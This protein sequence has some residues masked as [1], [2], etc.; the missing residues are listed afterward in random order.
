MGLR[1]FEQWMDALRRTDAVQVRTALAALAAL[2]L[3]AAI[4]PHGPSSESDLATSDREPESSPPVAV[5]REGPR[6][7]GHERP[8]GQ[9]GPPEA[10]LPAED[11]AAALA[12]RA[13]DQGRAS[14]DGV[15][16]DDDGRD[17]DGRDGDDARGADAAEREETGHEETE[18]EPQVIYGYDVEVR[19]EVATDT[20]EFEATLE[21]ILSDARGWTLG[22]SLAFERNADAPDLTVVL[23]SPDEVEATHEVCSRDY[24][25]RVEDEI[26]I[27]DR[28]WRD[29]TPAWHESDGDLTTYR[30]Y[31]INHEVG[32]FLGFG[33]VE[34]GG[35]GERA[36]VMQQQSVS[37]EECEP[38]GWP[39][40]W[41]REELAQQLDIAVRR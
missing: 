15:G 20:D 26:L 41:E 13:D 25:C 23:A 2:L 4:V 28:N 40:E 17:D 33:H 32:H 1:S 8:H 18:G 38:N 27:N 34:C 10:A 22:G 35:D 39:L 7:E 19:G 14:A 5:D 31:L 29:A 36:P 24:S 30:R 9:D 3:L 37:M 16:Q 6:G 12:D 21:R 11:H